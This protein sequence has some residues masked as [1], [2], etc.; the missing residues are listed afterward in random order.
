MTYEA[1]LLSL[2]PLQHALRVILH[3]IEAFLLPDICIFCGRVLIPQREE[4]KSLLQEGL[5]TCRKCMALLP[6][7][8]PDEIFSTCLSNEQTSDPIPDFSVAVPFRYEAPI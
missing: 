8:T 1:S 5:H 3:G 7:C 2:H 6:L 4:D